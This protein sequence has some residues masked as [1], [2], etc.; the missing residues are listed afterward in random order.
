MGQGELD[1]LLEK[2]RELN[3]LLGTIDPPESGT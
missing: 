2:L 3:Q 1:L